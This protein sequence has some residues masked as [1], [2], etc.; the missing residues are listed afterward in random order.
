M[1]PALPPLLPGLVVALWARKRITIAALPAD[2]QPTSASDAARAI[3]EAGGDPDPHVVRAE[4]PLATF[5]DP[6]RKEVRLARPVFDGRTPAPGGSPRT[7]P[8]TRSS[9]FRDTDRPLCASRWCSGR[10]CVAA[11]PG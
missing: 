11:W 2:E 4:P 5:H 10:G 9:R 7:R 8:V 1:I 3:L 6:R